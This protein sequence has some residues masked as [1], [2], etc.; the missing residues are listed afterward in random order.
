MKYMQ[1]LLWVSLVTAAFWAGCATEPELITLRP[2]PEP[3]PQHEEKSSLWDQLEVAPEEDPRRKPQ[4]ISQTRARKSPQLKVSTFDGEKRKIEPAEEGYVTLMVFWSVD[5]EVTRAA[6]RHVSDLAQKYSAMGVRAV[7]ILEN[8]TTAKYAPSF[9]RAQGIR[10]PVYCDDFSAL[11]AMG[12]AARQGRVKEV[13]CFFI[14][15][16]KRRVRFFKRG[17][18][19][20]V[21]ATLADV[22][23]TVE[24]EKVRENAAEGERIE[25]YLK[26]LLQEQ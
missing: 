9:L 24:K 5:L 1:L 7:G 10:Y 21:S 18:A 16:R 20:T 13:P 17:F 23:R 3:A 14:I 25:D 22:Q 19:F 8:P 6:A 2:P 12:R 26:Q 4:L 15:D 11:R